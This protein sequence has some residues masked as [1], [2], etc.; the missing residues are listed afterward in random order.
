ML[1]EERYDKILAILE[2]EQYISA[3]GL[4]EKLF[5]SLPTIRR[6]LAVLEEQSNRAKL[7]QQEAKAHAKNKRFGKG[8]S[9]KK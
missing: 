7:R 4:S 6:D 8:K 9:A 3:S 1:K 2:E 5:V